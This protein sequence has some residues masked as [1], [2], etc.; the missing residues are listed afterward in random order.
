MS[1]E[2]Y[3]LGPKEIVLDTYEKVESFFNACLK[4]MEWNEKHPYEPSG[5]EVLEGEAL[6]EWLR[7]V[8]WITD[9]ES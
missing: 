7:K 5:V 6:E 2:E 3:Y 8:G 9:E 1:D 4:S